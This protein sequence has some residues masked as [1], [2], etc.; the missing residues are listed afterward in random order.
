MLSSLP[1]E[2]AVFLNFALS[3]R[4]QQAQPRQPQQPPQTPAPGR[5]GEDYYYTRPGDLVTAADCQA[6]GEDCQGD[7]AG[8]DEG[9]GGGEERL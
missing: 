6:D 2:L 1:S 7:H 4:S 5:R 3:A 8:N 9:K